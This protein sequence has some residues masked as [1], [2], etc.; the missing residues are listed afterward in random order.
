MAESEI[1]S[2]MVPLAGAHLLIPN[3]TVAE[4]VAYSSPE[5]TQ[6]APD[7]LLGTFLWRGWQVP[8]IS[9][10]SLTESNQAEPVGNARLCITKT[11]IDNERMPYIAI[12]AQGFPRL[13][14]ITTD[15]VTEVPMQTKPIAVAGKV[16]VE[17]T[18]AFVPDLDRLGH[19]VAHATFGAL[20]L[21][22]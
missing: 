12:L 17:N 3:A 20:P 8:L 5:P 6:D 15:N 13:T 10:A 11:L 22:S 4:V 16:I 18:E 7:W 1:R 19:L 14:T 9:F 2:V 21:T